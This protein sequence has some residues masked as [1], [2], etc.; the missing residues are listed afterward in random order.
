[1]GK[2]GLVSCGVSVLLGMMYQY[3]VPN[4]GVAALLI[5]LWMILILPGMLGIAAIAT[6]Q[7][8]AGRFL[9][10]IG[11]AFGLWAAGLILVLV[12]MTLL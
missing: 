6:A 7:K 4:T 10:N 8:S 1:M 9:G 12:G 3:G 5:L 2:T 11:S